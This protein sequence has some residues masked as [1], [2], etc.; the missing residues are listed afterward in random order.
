MTTNRISPNLDISCQNLGGWN[1]SIYGTCGLWAHTLLLHHSDR[2]EIFSE[3][4][5]SREL[6]IGGGTIAGR[7]IITCGGGM[8]RE[9][10][11]EDILGVTIQRAIKE[12][13]GDTTQR[14]IEE[15]LGDTTQRDIE[16]I[17]GDTTQ[18]DIEEILGDTTQRDIEEILGDT[19]QRDTSMYLGNNISG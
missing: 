18:R 19:T 12:I 9:P 8:N 11:P 14:D 1:T 7:V 4:K 15:I 2:N 17:L 5:E 13:L 10:L 6:N 16:E 3:G